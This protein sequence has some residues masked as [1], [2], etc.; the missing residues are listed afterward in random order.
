MD[1]PD[2]TQFRG[3]NNCRNILKTRQANK[4]AM[5]VLELF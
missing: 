3:E 4:W 1:P 5:K 2:I